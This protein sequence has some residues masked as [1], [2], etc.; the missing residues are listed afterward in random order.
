MTRK[1]TLLA[2]LGIAFMTTACNIQPTESKPVSAQD[3]ASTEQASH[4]TCHIGENGHEDYCLSTCLCGIGEADCDSSS[5]CA[6]GLRCLFNVGA[7]YGFEPD[8]DVCDCPPDSYNGGGSFCSEV[9]PC[10]EG[11]A[12][13]DSD[14]ECEAGLRCYRNVGDEFGFEEDDDV[15]ASCLPA[16]ANGTIDYCNAACPCSEGEGD[17]DSDSDCDPG[18]H[19]FLNA[20]ADFGLDPDIDVCAACRPPSQNGHIH[21]CTPDCPCGPGEGDCD[22]DL[23][24]DYG[25]CEPGLTCV[26]NVGPQ[27][28]LPEGTDVCLDLTP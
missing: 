7:D 5:H 2:T 6:P 1:S 3:V 23:I 14:A 16:E 25:D 10:S 22:G 20:G 19:C 24:P 18:L 12:D 9:C 8:V 4:D 27:L 21:F 28:G 17:C 11:Q 15:C 26:S 13:C